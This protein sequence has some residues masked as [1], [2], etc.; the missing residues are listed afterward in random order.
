MLTAVQEVIPALP[1][2]CEEDKIR[3]RSVLGLGRDDGTLEHGISV[4]IRD[5][6]TVDWIHMSLA[7]DSGLSQ[8]AHST[9]SADCVLTLSPATTGHTTASR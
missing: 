8:C 3:C 6:G 7:P 1:A 9:E 4:H 2:Q 5:V